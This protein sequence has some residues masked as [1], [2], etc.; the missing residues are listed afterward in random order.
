MDSNWFINDLFSGSYKTM[1][2]EY[3][4][5]NPQK[6]YETLKKAKD[7]GYKVFR[8]EKGDHKVEQKTY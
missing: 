3:W 2:D 7:M 8:N 5:S 6:Y 4:K 1:L